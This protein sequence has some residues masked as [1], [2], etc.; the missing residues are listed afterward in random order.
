VKELLVQFMDREVGI[1]YL[2]PH[3]IDPA[4]IIAVAD[5]YF[6]IQG[7]WDDS[8]HHYPYSN[9]IQIAEK[10]GGIEIGGPFTHKHRYDVVIKIGHLVDVVP[11]A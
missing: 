1:N 7:K 6:S 2:R 11:V 3:H 4:T 9:I 10:E 8:L 5:R